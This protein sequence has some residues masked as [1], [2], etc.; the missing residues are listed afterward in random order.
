MNYEK[1]D[2]STQAI[3]FDH[4]VFILLYV[5]HKIA[6]QF[7]MSTSSNSL[8][9]LLSTILILQ[10]WISL[11]LSNLSIP[12]NGFTSPSPSALLPFI[13]IIIIIII[14]ITFYMSYLLTVISIG[15]TRK[16]CNGRMSLSHDHLSLLW[17]TACI[18]PHFPWRRW[19]GGT[20]SSWSF[21]RPFCSR[22]SLW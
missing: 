12:H 13:I 20:R 9:N 1:Y 4:G 3:I 8:F 5:I 11:S 15:T 2:E 10:S 21:L 18:S 22:I 6:S 7:A 16:S 17:W 19:V 14:I